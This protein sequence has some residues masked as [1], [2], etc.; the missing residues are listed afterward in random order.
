MCDMYSTIASLSGLT[1]PY[2]GIPDPYPTLAR[3]LGT[4][5]RGRVLVGYEGKGIKRT[6]PVFLDQYPTIPYSSLPVPD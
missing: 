4:R 6:G 2:K 3:R 5:A 1:I